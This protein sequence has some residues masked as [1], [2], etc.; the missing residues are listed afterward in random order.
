MDLKSRNSIIKN[1]LKL[2]FNSEIENFSTLG[3]K[4]N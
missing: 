3:F 1:R 2:L 4:Y